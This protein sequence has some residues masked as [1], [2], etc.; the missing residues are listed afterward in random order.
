[1]HASLLVRPWSGCIIK[2]QPFLLSKGSA[3]TLV[4]M[5]QAAAERPTVNEWLRIFRMRRYGHSGKREMIPLALEMSSDERH[6]AECG[7][8]CVLAIKIANPHVDGAGV[9]RHDTSSVMN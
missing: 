6:I 4:A 3:Y 1:M 8:P 2:G 7:A 9:V 5:L